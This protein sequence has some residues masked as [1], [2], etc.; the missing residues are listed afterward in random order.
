L[1]S[2][3]TPGLDSPQNVTISSEVKGNICSL[4]TAAGRG[5]GDA[6]EKT[7]FRDMLKRWP[8]DEVEKGAEGL[9]RMRALGVRM[10][11]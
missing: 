10:L 2:L 7:A 6:G 5:V 3:L 9:E 8:I 4:I 11:E 1:S